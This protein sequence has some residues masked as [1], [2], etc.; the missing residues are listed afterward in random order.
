VPRPKKPI[1]KILS[2]PFPVAQVFVG[3]RAFTLETSDEKRICALVMIA[4][5]ANT[6]LKRHRAT[7][8]KI[9][10]SM[11][12][13]DLASFAV[14][15]ARPEIAAKTNRMEKRLSQWMAK[16]PDFTLKYLQT[17]RSAAKRKPNAFA[18]AVAALRAHK[19]IID[20][21]GKVRKFDD[22]QDKEICDQLKI[23]PATYKTAK[24]YLADLEHRMGWE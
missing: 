4:Q 11:N 1:Y 7:V 23:S 24:T 10:S 5:V 14:M 9:E 20:A 17:L 18:Q 16:F 15:A 2:G 8:Q 13:V 19:P 22:A 6:F 3:T 12:G 21:S